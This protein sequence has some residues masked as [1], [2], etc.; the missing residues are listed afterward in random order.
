MEYLL[1][2]GVQ[3]VNTGKKFCFLKEELIKMDLKLFVRYLT[4]MMDSDLREK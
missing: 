3:M 2:A 1:T 4:A